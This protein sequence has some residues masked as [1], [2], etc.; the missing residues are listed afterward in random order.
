MPPSQQNLAGSKQVF[1]ILFTGY[2][3]FV[4]YPILRADRPCNDDMARMLSGAYSWNDNGR[5]LTTA[6]MR[7]LEGNLPRLVDFSPMP[8]ILA[9]A[10]LALAGVLIARRHAIQSPWLAAMLVLPLGAQ[11][12]FLENLSFRFDAVAMGAS[13]LLAVLPVS[14]CRDNLRGFALGALALLGCLCSYQPC[15]NVFLIF[16]L[17]DLVAAQARD[18]KPQRVARLAA[19]YVGEALLAMLVY[20]WKVAP[21]IKDWIHEHSQMIHSPQQWDVVI[22]N[23]KNMAAFLLHALARRWTPVLVWLLALTA[24]APATI[25]LHYAFASSG[26]RTQ[27][28]WIRC[29]LALFAILLP[30]VALACVAGPMLLLVSPIISPRVFP[31]V[32]ALMVASLVTLH[33]ALRKWGAGWSHALCFTVAGVWALGMLGFASIYGNALSAQKQYETQIASQLANDL[34]ELQQKQGITRFLMDGSAG[35]SPLSAHAAEVFPVLNVLVS[36]YLV[37]NDFHSR[38]F[39]KLFGT[40]LDEARQDPTGNAAADALLLRACDAPAVYVRNRYALRVVDTTAVVTFPG[41]RP[42]SCP[43]GSSKS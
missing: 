39:V 32:G 13:V 5:P 12:F 43:G 19:F 2:L 10:L 22:G 34:A 25:G 14:V 31:G 3:L 7:L 26:T 15:L 33:I 40:G 23:A 27:P 17:L 38:N 8:Q 35:L 20:Q 37:G 36:P 21:S 24:L 41:G 42:L 29:G 16:M 11:P 30:L 9:I 4:L 6:L 1:G 28:M 18:E